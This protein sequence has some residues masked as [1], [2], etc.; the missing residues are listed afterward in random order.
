M[1]GETDMLKTGLS[2]YSMLLGELVKRDIKIKYKGSVLGIIW[3]VLNPLLMMLV[4]SVVFTI[5]FPGI[6]G[7]IPHYVVYLITGQVFFSSMVEATTLSM[8]SIVGNGALLRKVYVPKYIF[9]ISKVLSTL[10]SLG[11]NMVSVFVIMAIDGV[12]F[13]WALL[14]IPV[15]V[16]Y[17]LLFMM[18]LGLLL[19]TVV[20][21]FRDI[22]HI[23]SVFTMAW[24]YATPI[25]YD[26]KQ[27]SDQYQ[28]IFKF[29]PMYQ[30]I[31][32]FRM[33]VIEHRVPGWEF[34]AICLGMG[35]IMLLIGLFVFKMKQYKFLNYV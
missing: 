1:Y 25:F 34:N 18:G 20:V 2:K 17:L 28:M 35:V 26:V 19:S 10:V 22:E 16:M 11:F 30:Y 27:V 29:N 15:A 31:S 7:Q 13:S 33:I 6:R 5:V 4:M 9:P 8:N 23:Y 24:M 12:T 32:F 14:M 21:F 3:S